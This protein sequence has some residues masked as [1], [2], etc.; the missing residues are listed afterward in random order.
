MN[1]V[2]SELNYRLVT[3]LISFWPVLPKF[4]C[5]NTQAYLQFFTSLSYIL[6]ILLDSAFSFLLKKK[7][8][9]RNDFARDSFLSFTHTLHGRIHTVGATRGARRGART[10]ETP[11]PTQASPGSLPNEPLKTELDTLGGEESLTGRKIPEEPGRL[12]G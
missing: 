2:R 9:E 12:Q 1:V 10:G 3:I 4:F 6:L 7:K 11:Q 8:K 5:T